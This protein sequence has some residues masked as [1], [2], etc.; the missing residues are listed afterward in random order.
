MS[1]Q[2]VNSISIVFLF[3]HFLL[4]SGEHVVDK[5]DEKMKDLKISISS[6]QFSIDGEAGRGWVWQAWVRT[7]KK[8]K[9]FCIFNFHLA[10]LSRVSNTKT[11]KDS[12]PTLVIESIQQIHISFE[13]G[14]CEMRL[15]P[16]FM[17][18][19]LIFTF[20]IWL[21]VSIEC[22]RIKI[23]CHVWPKILLAAHPSRIL[24]TCLEM[25]WIVKIQGFYH[26]LT[27]IERGPGA[28]HSRPQW[29]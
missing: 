5:L 7:W 18:I 25:P 2:N 24:N 8:L 12:A 16:P 21:I 22:K 20:K 9:L 29:L 23:S 27:R 14:L 10:E 4:D 6:F 1:G 26:I 13:F 28:Q 15:Y 19:K 17:K 11:E 3:L